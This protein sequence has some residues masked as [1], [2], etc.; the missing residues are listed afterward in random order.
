[1]RW[2]VCGVDIMSDRLKGRERVGTWLLCAIFFTATELEAVESSR[3]QLVNHTD[4]LAPHGDEF[5]P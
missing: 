4:G 2:Y 3:H 5:Y 1:M